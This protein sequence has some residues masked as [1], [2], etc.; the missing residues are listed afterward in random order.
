MPQRGPA[1]APPSPAPYHTTIPHRYQT[2]P[3]LLFLFGKTPNMLFGITH[4]RILD[5]QIQHGPNRMKGMG[6]QDGPGPI[7]MGHGIYRLECGPIRME[8]EPSDESGPVSISHS[9]H[10]MES[11]PI[12][13]CMPTDQG[14]GESHTRLRIFHGASSHLVSVPGKGP[15]IRT[16]SIGGWRD[17]SAGKSTDYSSKGP[18]F[19]YQ[20]PHG[21]SQP[22]VMRSDAL[23]WCI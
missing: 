14:Q 21:G 11:S 12:T 22:P 7:K 15:E 19:K 10:R 16:W 20:Q 17:G 3:W 13:E 5:C 9:T 1:E 4:L 2:Y 23:F 8:H 6:K 18:E